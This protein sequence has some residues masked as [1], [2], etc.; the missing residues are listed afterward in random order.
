MRRSGNSIVANPVLVGAT[1][2]LVVIIAV[3]LAYNANKGLPFVPTTQLKFYVS[4]GANLLPGNDVREGGQRVGLVEEMVPRRLPD[5]RVGALVTLK[6]DKVA[7]DIP[8]DSRFSL[9]PRSVLGLKYV[10]ITRGKSKSEFETGGT[11]PPDQVRYPVDL[12]QFYSIFDKKTRTGVQGNLRG[13]GDTFA[14]RG[15]S[16]NETLQIA[17]NFLMH[18]E[19]VA[20][21]LADTDTQLPRFFKEL[22][23]ATRILAPV[24]DRYARQFT[25]AANTFEAWSR[26]PDRLQDTIERQA[27]TMDAGIESFRVQRPFLRD[28]RSFSISL[29]RASDTFPRTLPRITSALQTGIPVL[30]RQPEINVELE[31]TFRSLA[32]LMEDPG[33]PYALRSLT[34]LVGI[35]NPLVKFVGP[36]V[37]TCN[38]FNY[39]FTNLGEHITEPDP[40]GLSQRTLLNQAPRP[41]NPAD[42]SLGSLGARRPVNGEPVTSGPVANFHTSVYPAAI[43]HKGN[44][45]CEGGQRG[46]AEKLTAYNTDPK[47]KIVTDPRI[48]G[49]QGPTFTGR[50][51]VPEGQTFSRNPL[52]GPPL[53]AEL[54]TP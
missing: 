1:T 23:D 49:N 4:S 48:P 47:L 30:G 7:G 6:L 14:T 39:A 50:A 9:R 19:P 31:K 33:T 26:Y 42:P 24:A 13:F 15:E 36:Y 10:E 22:G 32:E 44:A 21:T 54:D 38:Y 17:P 3:F 2:T 5:G 8:V 35:L 29:R 28:L 51:R 41:V 46:Y 12:D 37:T 11:V 18:L 20:K 53:P 45:D 34:R 40:T 16:I 25:R 52:L 27:P 43:D